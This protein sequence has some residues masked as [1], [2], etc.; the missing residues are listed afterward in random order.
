MMKGKEK[1]VRGTTVKKTVVE[2]R[3]EREGEGCNIRDLTIRNGPVLFR[4]Q[5]IRSI[6][7]IKLFSQDIKFFSVILPRIQQQFRVC[8]CQEG[9]VAKPGIIRKISL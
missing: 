9:Q 3:A 7:C 5:G 6:S 2:K 8:K 4:L 1:R